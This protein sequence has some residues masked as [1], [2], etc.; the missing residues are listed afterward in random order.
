M[1]TLVFFP[2]LGSVPAAGVGSKPTPG[3]GRAMAKGGKPA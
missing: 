3:G 2:L 1:S